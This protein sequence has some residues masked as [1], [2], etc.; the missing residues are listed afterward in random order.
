M[1]MLNVTGSTQ[2]HAL[3]RPCTHTPH[4]KI[5]EAHVQANTTHTQTQQA[6][7]PRCTHMQGA[8]CTCALVQVQFTR[9]H[10][11]THASVHRVHGMP[12][13]NTSCTHSLHVK[14][15][16]QAKLSMH[17]AQRLCLNLDRYMRLKVTFN[18]MLSAAICTRATYTHSARTHNQPETLKHDH[19]HHVHHTHMR[20]PGITAVQHIH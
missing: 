11:E 7:D 20:M 1:L 13:R 12:T 6:Y 9:H 8:V 14:V 18:A 2:S 5:P 10:T 19:D 3:R 15:Q 17:H 16:I 4:K